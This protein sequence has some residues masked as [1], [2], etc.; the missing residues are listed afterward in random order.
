MSLFRTMFPNAGRLLYSI[1]RVEFQK[2][3][4][5]HAHIPLKYS[6]DCVLP[7]DIDRIIS[8]QIPEMADDAGIV[9]QFMIHPF[10]HS[11]TINN[12]PPSPQHPLKYCE[13]WKDGA[14]M[15]RFGY[16]KPIQEKTVIDNH[17]VFYRWG[18][19]DAFVVPHCLPL[20]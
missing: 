1:Q 16:P 6:K 3:G 20:I 2:R 17:R 5:P 19:E 15:C 18:E 12:I 11:N 10:H 14:R 4:L 13:K 8:A 7:E 9:C